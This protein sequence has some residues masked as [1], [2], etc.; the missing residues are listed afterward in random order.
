MSE[1][2]VANRTL[3]VMDNLPFLRS[4][5]NE[6]IDLIAIDP[7]FAA[8]ETFTKTPKPPITKDELSEER[9]IAKK[10][11]V[12]HNEGIGET[13]VRDVWE[14]GRR[15]SPRL[16]DADGGRLPCRP[17]GYSGGRSLRH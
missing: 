8:N 2:N 7:P 17:R 3:A 13:R 14:L 1:L 10:H 9:A 6:C 4:L 5:N 12:P 11:G 15:H 16:E